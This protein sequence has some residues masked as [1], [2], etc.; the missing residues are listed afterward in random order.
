M[1]PFF[2]HLD[3]TDFRLHTFEENARYF[4]DT[5]KTKSVAH[6]RTPRSIDIPN[7]GEGEKGGVG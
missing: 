2:V 3:A 7:G 4:M 6:L 1:W 5:P